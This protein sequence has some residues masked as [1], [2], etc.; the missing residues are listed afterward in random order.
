MGGVTQTGSN[1]AL[2]LGRNGP[3]SRLPVADDEMTDER[4]VAPELVLSHC[5]PKVMSHHE[6]SSEQA[7]TWRCL[8]TVA[9]SGRRVR[10]AIAQALQW[11]SIMGAGMHIL[12][13]VTKL[14]AHAMLQCRA[15]LQ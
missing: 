4:H 2:S 10:G 3:K 1:S 15:L 7:L 6:N 12:A 14:G 13:S 11:L 8:D 5:M 9:R